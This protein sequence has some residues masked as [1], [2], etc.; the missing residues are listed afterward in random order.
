MLSLK[1]PVQNIGDLST[2]YLHM[3][4]LG[5]LKKTL[6]REQLQESCRA[7]PQIKNLIERNAKI[8]K[9]IDRQISSDFAR[10]FMTKISFATDYG[11]AAAKGPT[12]SDSSV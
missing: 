3:Q 1:R 9:G 8:L 6:T 7:N 12:T 4:K 2:K 11:A 10:K 5:M